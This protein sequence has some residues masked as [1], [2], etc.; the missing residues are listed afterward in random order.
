MQ[1]NPEPCRYTESRSRPITICVSLQVTAEHAIGFGAALGATFGFA[2][3]AALAGAFF[4]A[5]LTIFFAAFTGFFAFG[6]TFFFDFA[7][8]SSP[9]SAEISLRE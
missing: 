7:I 2:F 6:A 3:I 5:F 8:I 9:C 1:F 4:A